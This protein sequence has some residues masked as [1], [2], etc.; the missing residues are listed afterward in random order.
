MKQ[1]KLSVIGALLLGL[2]LI[3]YGFREALTTHFPPGFRSSAFAR[4]QLGDEFSAVT[5]ELGAPLDFTLVPGEPS[6]AVG[7]PLTRTNAGELASFASSSRDMVLM[8]YSRPRYVDPYKAYEVII[9]G[10]KVLVKRTY[11]Y[12]D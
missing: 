2:A 12:W 3:S 5:N 7:N 4:V 6:A 10:G 1:I 11:W 8:R 9:R